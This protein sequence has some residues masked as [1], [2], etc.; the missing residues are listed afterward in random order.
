VIY[1]IPWKYDNAI[2]FNIHVLFIWNFN[3]TINFL[4]D[5]KAILILTQNIIY[6]KNKIAF[7]IVKKPLRCVFKHMQMMVEL[8]FSQTHFF[9][10][11]EKTHW[12]NVLVTTLIFLARFLLIV[13]MK[14]MTWKFNK[15]N[16]CSLL[17]I[18]TAPWD[19]Q[20]AGWLEVDLFSP[21]WEIE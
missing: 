5:I 10:N 18:M 17:E 19:H 21:R 8:W 2:V 6:P 14:K 15:D 1:F 11:S 12:K 16:R 9:Y 3:S 7:M 20:T 13:W 4:N